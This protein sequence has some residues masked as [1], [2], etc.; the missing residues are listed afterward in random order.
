MA[1]FVGLIFKPEVSG[2]AE[3]LK[4]NVCLLFN[5]FTNL[6]YLPINE[7]LYDYYLGVKSK[8]LKKNLT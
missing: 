2:C 5:Q 4:T 3:H 7:Y 1:H 8:K 6:E